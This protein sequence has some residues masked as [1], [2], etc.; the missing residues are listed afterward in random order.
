[1]QARD[2]F[3]RIDRHGSSCPLCH[4]TTIATSRCLY[5]DFSSMARQASEAPVDMDKVLAQEVHN[6]SLQDRNR[7][8][9]EVHGVAGHLEEDP[10]VISQRLSQFDWHLS[11]VRNKPAYDFA[12]QQ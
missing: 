9:E 1:M 7:V 10:K 2:M 5:D 12:L 4:G 3:C 8:Y 11:T 6:L